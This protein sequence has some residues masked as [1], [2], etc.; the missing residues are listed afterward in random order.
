MT[1]ST[2]NLADT[3][4]V[5]DPNLHVSLVQVSP[6]LYENLDAD[7]AGFSGHVLISIHEFSAKTPGAGTENREEPAG[8]T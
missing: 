4:A 5:L 2:Q 7:F 6:A 3:Y 1:I 8:N